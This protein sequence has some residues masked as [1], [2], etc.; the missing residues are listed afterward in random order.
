MRRL[1]LFFSCIV[2]ALPLLAA[3]AETDK[4]NKLI[5]EEWQWQLRD[6]PESATFLGE[7]GQDDR[8]TDRSGRRGNGR[9][10]HNGRRSRA[11]KRIPG[12]AR[13]GAE[14]QLN[15]IF[16]PPSETG[17]GRRSL[18]VRAV[19]LDQMGGLYSV[20]A[21]WRSRFRGRHGEGPR[22]LLAA[23]CFPRAATTTRSAHEDAAWPWDSLRRV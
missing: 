9:R 8:L 14:Y 2:V 10:E 5:A 7:R 21:S 17:G 6:D 18:S 13:L 12:R 22:E 4:L 11:S 23:A 1:L 20:S 3:S 16:P 19:P 15:T